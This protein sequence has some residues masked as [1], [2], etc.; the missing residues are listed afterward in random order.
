MAFQY[1]R[2]SASG[3]SGGGGT[4]D[5]LQYIASFVVTNWTGPSSGEYRYTV[6]AA[7][8]GA[9]N[10]PIVQVE[11][12]DGSVYNSVDVL[13]EIN[14]SGDVALIINESPDTRFD[15]RIKIIGE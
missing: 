11:E 10:S 14:G 8:H 4:S 1:K 7:T 2:I 9:G 6:S 13:V 12:L 15:G 3:V 5:V